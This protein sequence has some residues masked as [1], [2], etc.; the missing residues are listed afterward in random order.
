[1][2]RKMRIALEKLRVFT[3]Q[4]LHATGVPKPSAAVVAEVFVVA[5]SRGV[6]HHD[7]SDLPGRLEWLTTGVVDAAAT[8][9]M[10]ADG[11][12]LVTMTANNCL[13]ELATF[14][15]AE[16]ARARARVHGIGFVTVVDSNHFLGAYPYVAWLAGERCLGVVMS[17]TLPSMGAPGLGQKVLGNNPI[18]FGLFRDAGTDVLFD[19]SVAYTSWG[20]LHRR[21][22]AGEEIPGHWAL[23]AHG[24][25]TTDPRAAQDGA[26]L[27][28]GGHKGVALSL[29][30][31]ALTSCLGGGAVADELWRDGVL[32]GLHSQC[33]LAIDPSTVGADGRAASRVGELV[34]RLTETIPG[35]QAPGERSARHAEVAMKGGVDVSAPV[36]AQLE[37]W[38]ATL[39]ID[40]LEAQPSGSP[41]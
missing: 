27:P 33:V 41:R 5:T 16:T 22:A 40:A 34:G 19:A 6:G 39:G 37:R 10:T 38:A 23:D 8:P 3:E 12:A 28:I 26:A 25:P 24:R 11:G 18:G 30:V 29:L 4:A 1:M 32:S 15:A 7:V 14:R 17:R 9:T 13:G 36:C 35:F 20:E 21:E 2:L 31:E